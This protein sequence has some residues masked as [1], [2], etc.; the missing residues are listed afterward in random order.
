MS[1]FGT[2]RIDGFFGTPA[3]QVSACSLLDSEVLQ[4]TASHTG[5]EILAPMQPEISTQA[6]L[7]VEPA[8]PTEFVNDHDHDKVRDH[9][10]QLKVSCRF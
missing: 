7:T 5:A 10:A 3:T 8:A 6:A 2:Q 9:G 1:L 4:A